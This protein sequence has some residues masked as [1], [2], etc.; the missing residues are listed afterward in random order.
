MQTNFQN[1][2]YNSRAGRQSQIHREHAIYNSVV[3]SGFIDLKTSPQRMEKL[4]LIVLNGI[5]WGSCI[6]G[7]LLNL[8]SW[9][10]DILF[11]SGCAFL[12]LKFIRIVLKTGQSYRREQI[13]QEILRKKLRD[14][15][16]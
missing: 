6:G 1:T 4:F 15:E 8:A 2:G 7:I 13:E 10:S 11:V 16:E 14:S 12:L 3:R 9:K 5:G